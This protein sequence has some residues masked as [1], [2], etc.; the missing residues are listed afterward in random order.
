MQKIIVFKNSRF[1]SHLHFNKISPFR[2]Y[3]GIFVG[4]GY[5]F[6]LYFFSSVLREALRIFSITED[7][8]ILTYSNSEM[9][10][11]NFFFASLSVIFAQSITFN[12]WLNKSRSFFGRYDYKRKMIIN[13]QRTL[14]WYFIGWFSK[15]TFL[16]VIFF[17]ITIP[18]GFYAIDFYSEYKYLFIFF[19]IVLFLQTWNTVRL[20][21]IRRSLAK[22]FITAAILSVFS[23]GLSKI[24]IVDSNSL[25]KFVKKGCCY[26]CIPDNLPKVKYFKKFGISF[27]NIYLNNKALNSPDSLLKIN[28]EVLS[29]SDFK[30]TVKYENP[31]N[32]INRYFISRKIYKLNIDCDVKMESV[33]FIKSTLINNGVQNISYSVLPI[34]IKF[35]KKYYHNYE[36]TSH[37]NSSY[38]NDSLIKL[39]I[40]IPTVQK[41]TKLILR[42]DSL[43]NIYLN[44]V[45][46]P[47]DSLKSA[48]KTKIYNDNKLLLVINIENDMTFGTYFKMWDACYEAVYELRIAYSTIKFTKKYNTLYGKELEDVLKQYPL[49]IF[50]MTDRMKKFF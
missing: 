1:R 19:L 27:R 29:I 30:Q 33:N 28:S 14:N 3:A 2:F 34:N 9:N 49:R 37:I 25:D 23:F 5:A 4:I 50:E 31:R 11:Y 47:K 10:F 18:N 44:D 16:F 24:H 38:L 26:K 17:F 48:V 32:D 6:V 20:T 13:E 45:L 8:N 36:V 46:I 12:F 21:F 22:I 43:Q 35:D 40:I 42:A 7:C 15:I 41:F 39:F